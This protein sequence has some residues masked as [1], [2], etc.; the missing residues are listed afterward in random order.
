MPNVRELY[1][2]WLSM[3]S[4]KK[5]VIRFGHLVVVVALLGV[6]VQCTVQAWGVRDTTGRLTLVPWSSD[7]IEASATF[8][9]ASGEWRS[10]DRVAS[11]NQVSVCVVLSFSHG[12]DAVSAVV[13]V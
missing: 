13:L 1:C 5:S 2:V 6:N 8:E 11:G 3:S 9:C 7:R 12:A 4:S 10:S